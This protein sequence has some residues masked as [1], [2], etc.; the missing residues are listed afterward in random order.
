MTEKK[1]YMNYK[2]SGPVPIT[3]S[4]EQAGIEYHYIDDNDISKLFEKY[5]ELFKEENDTIRKGK[6]SK[7]GEMMYFL[8]FC[9]K[10][11]SNLNS[12]ITFIYN[13]NPSINE[14]DL[15]ALDIEPIILGHLEKMQQH[16]GD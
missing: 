6:M 12:H 8:E 4:F 1:P 3:S 11:H 2:F 10:L 15:T 7:D 9:I 14:M 5:P 16:Q 13:N